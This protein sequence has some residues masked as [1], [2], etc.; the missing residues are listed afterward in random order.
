MLA[1]NWFLD[2][3][4]GWGGSQAGGAPA[5]LVHG[6]PLTVVRDDGPGHGRGVDA[7]DHPEH[8]EPAEVLTPLFPGQDFR[9]VREHSGNG[10]SDPTRTENTRAWGLTAN[11]R[12]EGQSQS[13]L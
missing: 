10:S 11:G 7:A 8:A 12:C 4:S 1:S 9:K 13:K 6:Q 2:E 3:E 5:R